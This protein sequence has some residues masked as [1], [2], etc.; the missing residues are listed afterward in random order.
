MMKQVGYDVGDECN[1]EGNESDLVLPPFTYV[2]SV[3]T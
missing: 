1:G 3:M 2:E